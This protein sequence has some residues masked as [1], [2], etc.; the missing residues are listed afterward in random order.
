MKTYKEKLFDYFNDGGKPMGLAEVAE[1]L[2]VPKKNASGML[3]DLELKDRGGWKADIR[4]DRNSR[5]IHGIKRNKTRN[6]ELRELIKSLILKDST[7]NN[8][9]LSREIGCSD[10]IVKKVRLKLIEEGYE[11]KEVINRPLPKYGAKS[12]KSIEHP[13]D[14]PHMSK[15]A[16]VRQLWPVRV[17]A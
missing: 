7:V 11:L 2:G 13:Q 8:W 16:K 9:K 5:Y 12:A 15:A 10:T 4:W 6:E 1:F 17:R 14:A 3:S